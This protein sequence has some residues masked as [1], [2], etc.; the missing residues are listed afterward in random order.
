MTKHLIPRALLLA[1][2][3][4]AAAGAPAAAQGTSPS[5]A[6]VAPEPVH[7]GD[8]IRLSVL[9]DRDLSGD[10]PVNSYGTVVLPL[11]GEVDVSRD[12]E[13][14]LRTRVIA[15]LREVRFG[16]DIEVVVLRRVRVM[17]E[18]NQPGVFTLE[19]TLTVSDAI[20]MA[21]GRTQFANASQVVLHRD[22][23]DHVLNL[24]TD[25]EIADA[26]IQSGDEIRVPRRSWLDLNAGSVIGAAMGAVGIIVTLVV[27]K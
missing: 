13:R 16:P 8:V 11:L 1:L 7:P 15:A 12:D 19:P 22:G 26:P 21:Q 14:T 18:V 9:S 10:Y 23:V 17:G 4:L 2:A 25:V 6:G 27:N 24:Y 5:G 20:A 3:W